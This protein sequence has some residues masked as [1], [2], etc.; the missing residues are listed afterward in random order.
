MTKEIY[1]NAKWQIKNGFV[2]R[3]TG[4]DNIQWQCQPDFL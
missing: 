2:F 3:S 1:R 4:Q